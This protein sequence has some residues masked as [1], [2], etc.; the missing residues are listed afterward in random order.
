MYRVPVDFQ[1][2]GRIVWM[3]KCDRPQVSQLQTLRSEA[4][5]KSYMSRFNLEVNNM[6]ATDVNN[7]AYLN[8]TAA[9]FLEDRRSRYR[10]NP[11]TYPMQQRTPNSPPARHSPIADR[12]SLSRSGRQEGPDCT[13]PGIMRWFFRLLRADLVVPSLPLCEEMPQYSVW[14]SVSAKKIL[15]GKCVLS[16]RCPP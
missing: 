9:M 7:N 16:T 4:D 14:T 5:N 2:V 6:E 8:T 13:S 10:D 3:N 15:Y 1:S 11:R 12:G